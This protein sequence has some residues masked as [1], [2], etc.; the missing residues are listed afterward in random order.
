MRRLL[1]SHG[2]FVY[3]SRIRKVLLLTH[4]FDADW[5]PCD[6]PADALL[7]DFLTLC[8][9]T[10]RHALARVVF[11]HRSSI[12]NVGNGCDGQHSDQEPQ[13]LFHLE[14]P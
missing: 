10:A 1:L 12:G 7:P 6:A 4:P 2:D 14:S 5:W 3:P 13:R 9:S 11:N 8:C